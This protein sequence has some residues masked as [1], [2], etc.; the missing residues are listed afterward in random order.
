MNV[1]DPTG[2]A[3]TIS[4]VVP[5]LNELK[6]LPNLVAHLYRLRAHQTII[7][8][9]GSKDGSDGWLEENWQSI[10]MGNILVKSRAGRARQMNAGARIVS[11]DIIL[12]LHADSRLPSGSLEEILL[13]RENQFLWGRF[14]VEFIANTSIRWQMKVVAL[15]MNIRSRLT[16]IATGDQAI[17]I[18]ANLF[19][20]IGQF[21][22]VPLM[23]DIAI[24]KVLKKHSVP[25]CSNLK[26]RTSARRWEQGGVVRTILLMWYI[27]LA[28]FL[29]ANPAKL[30]GFY[31]RTR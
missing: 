6:H 15:F 17:F 24:S 5:V 16:S 30:V 20:E 18:D 25:F 28:Y 22:D 7:V 27:R 21:A 14:D 9:G 29:G 2:E 13:A 23:E 8:D 12:F 3:R 31:R 1:V 11:G 10:D 19:R 4:V 26:V